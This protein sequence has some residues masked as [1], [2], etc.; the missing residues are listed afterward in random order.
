MA[1]RTSTGSWILRAPTSPFCAATGARAELVF[2]AT[3]Y[4]DCAVLDADIMSVLDPVNASQIM[5]SVTNRS[6]L[7]YADIDSFQRYQ[8]VLAT[9]ASPTNQDWNS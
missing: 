3:V 4:A 8:R 2:A 5:G 9:Q 7:H 6:T 1:I